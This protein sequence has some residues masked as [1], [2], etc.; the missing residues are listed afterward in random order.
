MNQPELRAVTKNQ[1]KKLKS[2]GG[3]DRVKNK[4]LETIEITKRMRN[5][6]DNI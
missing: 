1:F 5:T 4:I 2:S 3:K 6:I